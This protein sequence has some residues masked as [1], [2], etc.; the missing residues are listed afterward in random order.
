MIKI[1]HLITELD[2]GGAE[3]MLQKLV[4]HMD[5]RQFHSSVVS[6]T[7]RGVIG[8]KI[9]SRGIRVF[10]LGMTRGRPGPKGLLKFYR[11]LKRE[12]PDLIQCWLYHADL[13]GFLVGRAAGIK[14]IAWGIRCSDMD[15]INYRI[16][17]KATVKLCARLSSGPDGIV[18]NS[19]KGLAVHRQLGYSTEK[20]HLIPNGFDLTRFSP[21]DAAKPWLLNHLG[22]SQDTILIGLVARYDPMKGHDIFLKAAAM[23]AETE[24]SA[25]FVMV[26]K[27]V[28]PDNHELLPLLAGPIMERVHLLGIRQDIPRLTAAFDIASSAS[29]GEGFSNTIG[30]AMACAVPCVATDTG[31]S[32]RILGGTGIIVPPGNPHALAR[33]WRDVIAMAP[34]VRKA[35]GERARKHVSDNFELGKVTRQF[36]NFYR[37]LLN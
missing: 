32:A 1:L 34:A 7:D 28:D 8:E 13:L 10:E 16:M 35:M 14:K 15:F 26:G 2:V 37:N 18:V 21:D 12:S 5:G 25:H 23:L 4:T 29:T 9:L 20:M 11:L 3:Q 27:D 31:D 19:E 22:L 24:K 33:A 30:E 6:M 17:T 36:E